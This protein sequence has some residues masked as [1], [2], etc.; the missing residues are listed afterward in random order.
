MLTSNIQHVFCIIEE[1]LEGGDDTRQC[2]H[3][4]SASESFKQCKFTGRAPQAQTASEL[5]RCKTIFTS[6][7]LVR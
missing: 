1:I 3:P 4:V 5:G 6:K 7:D 2:C